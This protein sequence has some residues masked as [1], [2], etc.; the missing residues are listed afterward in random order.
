MGA[1]Q[2][3]VAIGMAGALAVTLLAYAAVGARMIVLNEPLSAD[4][5][6]LAAGACL[7]VSIWLLIA[8][9]GIANF[10]FFSPPDIDGAGLTAPSGK[11]KPKLAILQNT[12][13]QVVLA[14]V[15]YGGV[16]VFAPRTWLALLLVLP[17][18]FSIGRIAFALGYRAGAAG[19]AFGF[20][21]TFYPTVGA[22]VLL[23]L[24]FIRAA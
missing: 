5:L 14:C 23:G 20:A 2:I 10:R 24:R 9:G 4:P 22:Y 17:V 1:K 16:A 18:L 13:E 6:R 11:L 21:L 8:V 3:G 15:A 7:A 19:R 12:L